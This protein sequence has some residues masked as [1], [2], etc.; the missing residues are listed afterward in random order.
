MSKSRDLIRSREAVHCF[1]KILGSSYSNATLTTKSERISEFGEWMYE[2][3]GISLRTRFYNGDPKSKSYQKRLLN[4]IGQ[5]NTLISPIRFRQVPGFLPESST[6]PVIT[7]LGCFRERRSDIVSGFVFGCI[8]E[9][10]SSSTS[11]LP[12]LDEISLFVCSKF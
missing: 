7:G 4:T 10:I 11:D 3:F 8:I 6:Y 2:N 9:Q 5:Y 1:L 12:Q